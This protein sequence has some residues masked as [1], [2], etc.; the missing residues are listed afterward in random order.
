MTVLR[1]SNAY[2]GTIDARRYWHPSGFVLSTLLLEANEVSVSLEFV[3]R[4]GR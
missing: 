1:V 4:L 2:E 3:L